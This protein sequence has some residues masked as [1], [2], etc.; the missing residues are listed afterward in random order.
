M[1][2]EAL[3]LW[4]RLFAGCA[5]YCC[6]A[7]CRWSDSQHID[8]FTIETDAITKRPAFL[9]AVIDVHKTMNLRGRLPVH[10]ELAAPGQGVTDDD[11]VSQFMEVRSLLELGDEHPFMPAP[12]RSGFATVRAL[13]ADEAGD[14]LGLLLTNRVGL[15]TT[16]HSLK[17]TCLSFAAKFGIGYQDR[18]VLGG[19]AHSGRMAEV[20]GRDAMARPLR[21]LGEVLSAIRSGSFV[22]DAN[23]AGRFVNAKPS[24]VF[25][26]EERHDFCPVL[27]AFPKAQAS[28]SL[29]PSHEDIEGKSASPVSPQHSHEDIEG[30][31]ASPVS[32]RSPCTSVLEPRASAPPSPAEPSKMADEDSDSSNSQVTSS[33]SESSSSSSSEEEAVGHVGPLPEAGDGFKFVQHSKFGTLHLLRSY[34]SRFTLCGRKIAPPLGDPVSVKPRT[35]VCRTCRKAQSNA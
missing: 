31:S 30:K 24:A 14:W 35:S 3:C 7:R 17:C 16:S 26:S 5:L 27:R 32:P 11:W 33:N 9:C 22:P 2:R 28:P 21:L 12:D 4:T 13:D 1:L 34:H 8:L 10:L 19:H 25:M 20:Y 15:R 18:L 23:R 6:Y 29:E